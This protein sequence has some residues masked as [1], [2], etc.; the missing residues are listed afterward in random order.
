MSKEVLLVQPYT[1][2]NEKQ[3]TKVFYLKYECQLNTEHDSSKFYP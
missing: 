1:L 2:K 3:G